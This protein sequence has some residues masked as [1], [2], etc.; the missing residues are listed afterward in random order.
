MSFWNRFKSWYS[1][2]N[3]KEHPLSY[4]V[5]FGILHEV[6][7]ILP[8]PMFYYI[9]K[10]SNVEIPFPKDM[11]SESNKRINKIRSAVGLKSMPEDSQAMLHMATS[12]AIVK[13]LMP[14][15]IGLCV[16]LTPHCAMFF[17]RLKRAVAMALT[18]YGDD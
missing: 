18:G 15:R 12:Y 7:A 11:L 3:L 9:L 5:S 6:T 16:Y 14:L 2:P 10:H 17:Q 13:V 4:I 8:L 1:W